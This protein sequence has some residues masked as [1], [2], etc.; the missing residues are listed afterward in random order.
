MCFDPRTHCWEC[1]SCFQDY[2]EEIALLGQ[3]FECCEEEQLRELEEYAIE[4]QTET[5]NQI[6]NLRSAGG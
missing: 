4:L 1:D 5:D 3:C 2:P 6:T